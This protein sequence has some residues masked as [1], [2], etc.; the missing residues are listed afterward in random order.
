MEKDENEVEDGAYQK[1]DNFFITLGPERADL[2][3]L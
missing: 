3:L 2:I 1:M